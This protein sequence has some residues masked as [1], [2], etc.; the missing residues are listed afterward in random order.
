MR[1]LSLPAPSLLA[2]SSAGLI[3]RLFQRTGDTPC[4]QTEAGLRA[5]R[6]TKPIVVVAVSGVVPVAVGY[7]A[8]LRVVV[9]GAP[10]QDAG[11]SQFYRHIPFKDRLK[12]STSALLMNANI[13]PERIEISFS[14]IMSSSYRYCSTAIFSRKRWRLRWLSLSPS[15]YTT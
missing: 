5:E 15:A 6:Q 7:A 10:T 8:V 12:L 11:R 9:P 2:K 3:R 4:S 13:E 14:S 1:S